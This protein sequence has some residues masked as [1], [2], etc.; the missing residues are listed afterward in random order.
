MMVLVS[1][2]CRHASTVLPLNETVD[3]VSFFLIAATAPRVIA[4]I[5]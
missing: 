4:M 3:A 5:E 1:A 2:H